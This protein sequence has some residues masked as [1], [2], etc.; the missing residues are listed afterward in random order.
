MIRRQLCPFLPPVRLQAVVCGLAWLLASTAS[1]RAVVINEIHYNP[2]DNTVPV[3]FIELYNEEAQPVS[4]AGWRFDD[5]VSFTFP[6]GTVLEPGG[7]LVIAANPAA[8]ETTYGV[9]AL[10]P[11]EGGLSSDGERLRLVDA[12]GA[13]RD[14]VTYSPS[15]PWPI[16]AN[17]EGGTMELVN[18]ALDND[19]GSS[20]RSSYLQPAVP[21]APSNPGN[22]QGTPGA[23]NKSFTANA[24][25]N[26]RQVQHTPREPK[27]EEPIVITAKV[28]DPEGVAS[29]TLE[30]QIVAPGAYVPAYLPN[31]VTSGNLSATRLLDA[32]PAYEE[33][34][35]TV[36][37]VDDGTGGD[38]VSG[39]G[40]YTVMLPAQANRTLLRY[41]LTV[42]DALGASQRWPFADDRRKNF[43]IFIYQ[44]VPDYEGVP[45]ARLTTLPVYHFLTRLED[46]RKCTA[47]DSTSSRLNAGPGYTFEN[48][49]GTIVYN[50]EVYDNIRYRLHGGNG[51]YDA[52]G[53][54]GTAPYGKRSF[55]LVFNKGQDFEALDQRGKP[56]PTKWRRLITQNLWENRAT[57][58]FSLNEAV[59]YY[60]FNTLGVPAPRTHWAHLRLI[61]T[62]EEQPDPYAGD[63]WGL[64]FCQ[65]NYDSRFLDAHDLPKGNLYKLNR[66]DPPGTGQL[67]Y[68]APLGAKNGADHRWVSQNLKGST[69]P[70]VVQSH[71]HLPLWSYYHALCHA[72]RHYDYWPNGDNNAAFYFYPD[73]KPENRHYG[74]LWVLPWDV[75]AT[76]GPTWNN[77]HD[78]VHNTLF[79]DSASGGGDPQTNPTLWPIYFS[80][81]REVRNLLWQP[82]QID[83]LIEWFAQIIRPFVDADLKR[84]ARGPGT[85]GSPNSNGNYGTLKVGTI[86]V[87]TTR[88]GTELLDLYI[89][90]MKKFAWTGGSWPGGNMIS[91][92]SARFLDNLQ[93]SLGEN[94]KTP[95]TP[96]IE[97]T[98]VA[99]FP[100]N[101]LKFKSSA[102]SDPQLEGEGSQFA[103]M[104]WRVAEITNPTAPGY[105]PADPPAVEW[106]ASWLSGAITS[107]SEEISPPSSAVRIGHTYRARVRHQD[108]TGRWSHWSEPVTFTATAPDLTAF[109]NDLVISQFLYRPAP[110]TA[111]E[112]AAGFTDAAF[113]EWIEIMNVGTSVLPLADLRFTKGIDIDLM[114]GALA[115]I[116]PGQRVLVVANR[117]AFESRYGAG[118]PI[119]GEWGE[120]GGRLNND[121]EN[122]KLSFGAGESLKEFVYSPDAPWPDTRGGY[123][124]VLREPT[125]RPDHTDPANWQASE[126][127]GGQPGGVASGGMV[128]TGEPTADFDHD[129]LPALLEFALGRSDTTAEIAPPLVMDA[130]EGVFFTYTARQ[131]MANVRLIL[132]VSMDL[133]TWTADAGDG[134]LLPVRALTET[135]PGVDT[136]RVEWLN[137]PTFSEAFARLRAEII[138]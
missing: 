119:V 122:L 60:L 5:G 133:Q 129:G 84:W 22:A 97:Y 110:V 90:D 51:R 48:W 49:H 10:G 83:P 112:V 17:G 69:A 54:N 114:G 65:E 45:A 42:A 91:G 2:P 85:A 130:T 137:A 94:G 40:I 78:L 126:G 125:S 71:V 31:P 61:T 87:N 134:S 99:D 1:T 26:I 59:N 32:N 124:L 72:I 21:N 77:G 98:G 113:F 138:P 115:H 52:S 58:T 13:V 70:E 67:R 116:Q 131:N 89:A 76:W 18:P 121:G 30:Y 50:G 74:Q 6:S 104:E 7:Y 93:R 102:F 105:D 101:G 81:V 127:L 75:D 33:G 29:V 9:T 16:S 132:E 111:E 123:A 136:L 15:F 96:S 86:T 43:A 56:Y 8:I 135:A 55:T 34:W 37:M 3:E 14:E 64:L 108:D 82:D 92:G 109:K 19:L 28:T 27:P 66:D 80:A 39:D 117:A 11:W 23:V 63:F 62:P 68:Q 79:N 47:Y 4:L 12:T 103:A 106:T 100:V 24:A 41:R 57:L 44:G 38:A 128:F 20:W 88:T 73:Y 46:Y 118:K 36:T 95:N 107:F 53:A 35:V 25:P 120:G